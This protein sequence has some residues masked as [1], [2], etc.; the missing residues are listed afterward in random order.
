M[1]RVFRTRPTARGGRRRSL[2]GVFLLGA[3]VAALGSSA[4]GE[5]VVH[6]SSGNASAGRIRITGQ[7]LDYTGSQLRMQLA[8]GEEQVFPGSRVAR[9]ETV[10]TAEQQE[11]DRRFAA[12]RHA[13][14]L[15][16]YQRA[17]QIEP[18]VW[19]RRQITAQIVRC[20][21]LLNQPELAGEEFLV[22][23]RSDP[24]TPDFDCIPLAW[25]PEEPS[26]TL[27]QAALGWLRQSDTPVAVLLGASH[28]LTGPVRG[29]AV[30]RLQ[31]LVLGG[32]R[33]VAQL[34]MAQLWRV[35]LVTAGEAQVLG[36]QKSIEQMPSGLRA[37]PYF[38][39]GTAWAQK[40]Q[41]ER[42]SLA[43]MRIPVL[44]ADHRRLAARAILGAAAAL[45]RLERPDQAARLYG[46]LV[47]QYDETPEVGEAKKRLDSLAARNSR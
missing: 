32:D 7:V 39:L 14:A 35:Q 10:T 2:P 40:Q 29:E 17:R 18:R 30:S 31:Q 24:E 37:G 8:G 21:W 34:A 16:L 27:E 46:E 12:G 28:L 33:R 4:A 3:A 5:D 13:E 45:E 36:W 38:V 6:L 44:Y 22:L 19:M 42:A 23:V 26:A 11:A 20:C 1:G 47:Q 9:I 43:W 41:W 25:M 15:A